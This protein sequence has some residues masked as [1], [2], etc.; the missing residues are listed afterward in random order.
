MS[1]EI[2]VPD[3]KG[4]KSITNVQ[5]IL[6]LA[7]TNLMSTDK[8]TTI[9]TCNKQKIGNADDILIEKEQFDKQFKCEIRTAGDIHYIKTYFVIKTEQICGKTKDDSWR[10]LKRNS[11]WLKRA[12]GPLGTTNLKALGLL[13]NV[14]SRN[15]IFQESTAAEK[16]GAQDYLQKME[17]LGLD[18]TETLNIH[19]Q[20]AKVTGQI[21]DKVIEDTKALIVYSE[22]DDANKNAILLEAYSRG[23]MILNMKYVP[24]GLKRTNEETFGRLLHESIC[25]QQN[26]RNMVK[27]G[28]SPEMMDYGRTAING[29]F[30]EQDS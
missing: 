3:K 13:S 23:L 16:S 28:V 30:P 26:T 9:E 12:L 5:K 7:F 14:P 25:K 29:N 18:D 20:R 15:I 27:Y 19:I 11:L 2:S 4:D 6:S 10:F 22:K 8:N 24:F 17:E 21:G 1:F